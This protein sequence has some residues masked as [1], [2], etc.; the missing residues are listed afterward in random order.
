MRDSSAN[1]G[2]TLQRLEKSVEAGNYYEAQQTYKTVYAR[3][4]AGRKYDEAMELLQAGA[5][6]QLKHGQVTCGAE[7]AV[8][9]IETFGK[10]SVPYTS[11]ALDRIIAIYNEFPK[12][13]VGQ[14]KAVSEDG[15]I[16]EETVEARTR[17]EGCS[18]FLKA[19]IKWSIESGGQS[20]GAPELH[21]MLAEYIWTQSPVPELGKASIHFLRGNCPEA[22][23][24]AVVDCMSKCYQGEADL[25]VARAILQYCSLGNLRD[26]N[27]LWSKVKEACSDKL[28]DT[29]LLHFIKFLLQTLE[30]DALPLFRMLR[31]NYK[32]SIERDP[33]FDEYLDDIAERFFN[34]RRKTGIQGMLGD[35][36]KMFAGV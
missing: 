1:S 35:I 6:V 21:K 25:V 32:L 16:S 8:L 9:L 36:M 28:P 12:V 30:R 20:K 19:A 15:S 22:F 4:M 18:S 23:A 34:V 26:A 31:Q 3:Y 5:S 29:P 14:I 2:K 11:T 27:I 33:T 10:A 7:L 24:S 17:V 13:D